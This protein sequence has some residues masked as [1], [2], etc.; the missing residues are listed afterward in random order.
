[1]GLLTELTVT[2]AKS[3]IKG[4]VKA[5]RDKDNKGK[6]GESFTA[7]ALAWGKL[8]GRDG[9][10][11]RNVY[12]PKENGSTTEIDLLFITQ[13]GIFVIESKYYSGII[14]GNDQDKQWIATILSNSGV[15]RFEFY[16]PIMQNSNH[17]TSLRKILNEQNMPMFSFIVFSDHCSIKDITTTAPNTFVCNRSRL[18]NLIDTIWK[19]SPDAFSESQVAFLANQLEP[20]TKATPEEKKNHITSV[21][22][23]YGENRE[24]CPR[25]GGV[26]VKRVVRTGVNAGQEFLGCSNFPRCRFT[27][28]I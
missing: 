8:F 28:N 24:L 6:I 2:L 21:T 27:K 26:L 13:K 10:I 4:A 18:N 11:L 22:E 5:S 17:V 25:C 15:R 1:M 9:I 19:Q 12:L 20:L 14:T 3:A 23:K 16:N 7:A